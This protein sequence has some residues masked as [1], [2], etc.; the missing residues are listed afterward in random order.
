MLKSRWRSLYKKV[1]SKVFN[2]KY[3][4]IPCVMLYN[5][6]IAK[7]NPCNRCWPLSVAELE[8]DNTVIKK[9][10]NKGESNKN[11][12]KIADWLREKT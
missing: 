11:A 7:H 1:E 12:R 8:L 6:C 3:I 5:F 2:L 10:A 9:R 4:V